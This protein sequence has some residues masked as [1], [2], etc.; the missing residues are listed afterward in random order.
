MARDLN[1]WADFWGVGFRFP[2]HFPLRTVAP[3]RAALVE[4]RLTTALYQAAW[5]DNRP[6]DDL[7]VLRDVIADAGGDPLEI[8]AKIQTPEIKA[9]LRD[10]F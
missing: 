3:L 7:S 5:R 1:D 9:R 4:P 8:E 10:T 6:I 2:D